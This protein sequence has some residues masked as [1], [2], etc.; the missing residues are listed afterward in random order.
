MTKRPPS[1]SAGKR[2][3]KFVEGTSTAL[4]LAASIA[5]QQEKKTQDKT[6]ANK[7][8]VS[9]NTEH[10]SPT[11][12]TRDRKSRS[13][14]SQ[15]LK[16]V[17]EVLLAR[18]KEKT[19][20]RRKRTNKSDTTADP[21]SNVF[22]STADREPAATGASATATADQAAKVKPGRKRVAFA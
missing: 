7:R 11:V 5:A 20:L 9:H 3:K 8:R 10:S 17:K 16:A 13:S 18:Q 6:D 4:E 22:R 21:T 19:K 2:P 14:G 1:A 12:T 15:K